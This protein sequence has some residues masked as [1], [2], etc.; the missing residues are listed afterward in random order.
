M[1]NK[2]HAAGDPWG[3]PYSL[4]S[5]FLAAHCG[6]QA[7][8]IRLSFDKKDSTP[9][10]SPVTARIIR[11]KAD[12]HCFLEGCP[13]QSRSVNGRGSKLHR[14]PGLSAALFLVKAAFNQILQFL[15]GTLGI[16]TFGRNEETATLAGGEHHQ[17]HDA[18]A[19]YLLTIL[20]YPNLGA[21][22]VRHAHKHG[23]RARVQA[24]L[25]QDGHFFLDLSGSR[26]TAQ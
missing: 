11:G 24:Q 13:G 22:L 19:V 3:D 10:R 9:V 16:R 23:C 6:W 15:K 4:K 26:S 8:V 5:D 21:M 20:L 12:F 17:T 25:V 14:Q 7:N 2:H 1:V 18:L